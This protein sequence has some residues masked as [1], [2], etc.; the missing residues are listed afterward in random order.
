MHVSVHV[1]IFERKTVT[2]QWFL[3]SISFALLS[4]VFIFLLKIVALCCFYILEQ[5]VVSFLARKKAGGTNREI[6]HLS[7]PALQPIRRKERIVSFFMSVEG[8]SFSYIIEYI[9]K[10]HVIF[11]IFLSCVT[12]KDMQ[13]NQLWNVLTALSGRS[14]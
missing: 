5:A 9:Q 6:K 4:Q 14:S 10:S 7:K 13:D 3:T 8:D 12:R 11:N 1:I 2:C